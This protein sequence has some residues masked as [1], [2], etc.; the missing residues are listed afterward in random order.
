MQRHNRNNYTRN[1][2]IKSRSFHTTRGFE[3]Y[4]CK[5]K[6]GNYHA[7]RRHMTQQHE[8][9]KK[10]DVCKMPLTS[11]E[12]KMHLCGTEKTIDCD[13]CKQQFSATVDILKHLDDAHAQKR[14][15]RCENCPTFFPMPILK[16]YHAAQHVVVPKLFIC[17]I[18]SK[19][20]AT[21]NSLRLHMD[22]HNAE[23]NHLCEECGK[24]FRTARNLEI[25]KR[26]RIHSEPQFECPDCP[27]KFIHAA[28][29][30]RHSD[31]H[32]DLKYVCDICNMELVSILGY[33][34]HM[35]K[36]FSSFSRINVIG[37][38]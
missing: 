7:I 35:S 33:N 9:D 31:L 5:I 21:N 15:Y 20:F 11:N 30:R 3:C 4:L 12:L 2:D 16:E 18:C 13:Y 17:E 24:G 28:D 25:H 6:V 19:R 14:L 1:T 26:S 37:H 22:T 10:C 36:W 29:L 38:L 27:R 8:R 32:R 34:D 23:K